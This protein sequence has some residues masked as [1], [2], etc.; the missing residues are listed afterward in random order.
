M[1]KHKCNFK[2]VSYNPNEI[3]KKCTKCNERITRATTKQEQK[4]IQKKNISSFKKADKLHFVWHKFQSLLDFTV[5]SSQEDRLR[6]A[7]KFNKLAKKYPNHVSVCRCDDGMF[8]GSDIF[9]IHSKTDRSWM[10]VNVVYIP[11]CGPAPVCLF[12][13]PDHVTGLLN[14][15]KFADKEKTKLNR[16]YKKYVKSVKPHPTLGI[17]FL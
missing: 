5:L 14:A 4:D 1:S 13:Y 10:G 6:L 8:M 11:Q 12:L 7:D 3:S 2:I 9:L 16:A 15:L 17:K